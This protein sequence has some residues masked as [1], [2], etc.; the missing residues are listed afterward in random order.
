M[1][2]LTLKN[3]SLTIAGVYTAIDSGIV[4]PNSINLV[5]G[6][7]IPV[8][9][10]GGPRGA[11]LQPLPRSGD[12]QLSQ[13]ITNDLR[14]NIK[15]ILLDESLPPDNMSARTA[16]EVAERMKQLSQNLG[17]AYGRL[18]N[19]TMYPVVK[20][21]L[22]VMDSLGIIQLPLKVNGLQV[23]I[24]PIGEIAMATNMVKVNKLMQYVQIAS[25]L[26]PTGQM[27]FK[28]EEICDIISESMG[29]DMRAITTFEERQQM[30]QVMEQQIQAQA[31][32]QAQQ[33]GMNNA[34][35]QQPTE[36]NQ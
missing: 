12:P 1:L 20:R 3:A 27:T 21:T 14:M 16:L 24:Q 19:E 31:Q 33:Q 18:I 5:P 11:D 2:E 34:T 28:V 25:S 9:S 36:V 17:S 10:N 6:A 13:I 22:E 35:E 7:I 8:S 4:N 23:K 15:K 30:Q 26:G 29:L 32:L